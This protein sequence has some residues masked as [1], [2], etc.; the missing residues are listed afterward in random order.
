MCCRESHP[1]NTAY[2]RARNT[3]NEKQ[4]QNNLGVIFRCEVDFSRARN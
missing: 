3:R 2:S 1:N 4:A